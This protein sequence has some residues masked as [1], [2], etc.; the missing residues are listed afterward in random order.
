MDSYL[1]WELIGYFGSALVLVSLLM[2]SIIKLRVINAVGSLIFCIYAFKINSIP[3]A[4]MNICLV[5]IDLYFL[6]KLI[7][8]KK[9]FSYVE[10]DAD[11]SVVKYV[12]D[13]FS[14]DIGKY[15]D[16]YDISKADRVMVVFDNDTVSGISAGVT[17]G[18][19]LRIIIDYTTPQ[20]RDCSVAN[21]IYG[22]LK[23]SYKTLVYTGSNPLHVPYCLKMGYEKTDRGY[24]KTL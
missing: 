7:A 4:I 22:V 1:I 12:L 14:G 23:D 15:F 24:V 13:R 16:A 21:Y 9:T 11:D 3:T 20:Y 19:S 10:A 8:S 2:S 17:E 5:G 18:D 6:Y